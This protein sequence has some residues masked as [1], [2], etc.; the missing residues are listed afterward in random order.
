MGEN[1][2]RSLY[3]FFASKCMT[4]HVGKG[5]HSYSKRCTV[6]PTLIMMQSQTE[7]IL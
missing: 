5:F 3:E 4:V 1:V 2:F 6:T 7:G